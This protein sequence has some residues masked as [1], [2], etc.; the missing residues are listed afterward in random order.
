MTYYGP[1]ERLIAL[2]CADTKRFTAHPTVVYR[3]LRWKREGYRWTKTLRWM[4]ESPLIVNRLPSANRPSSHSIA[5][6]HSHW[7]LYSFEEW[8]RLPF[9]LS[10]PSLPLDSRLPINS[11]LKRERGTVDRCMLS[12]IE[13][14]E[15]EFRERREGGIGRGEGKGSPPPLPSRSTTTTDSDSDG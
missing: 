5:I 13:T 8:E 2:I 10:L 1:G 12:P 4:E 9:P 14:E 15:M 7:C 11:V 6:S 3:I